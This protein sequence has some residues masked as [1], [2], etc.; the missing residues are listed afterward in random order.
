MGDNAFDGANELVVHASNPGVAQAAVCSGAGNVALWVNQLTEPCNN[1]K[2]VIP[3]GTDSFA[4]YGER[5]AKFQNVQLVSHARKTVINGVDLNTNGAIVLDLDSNTVDLAWCNVKTDGVA[6][7]LRAPR[8]DVTIRGNCS[9]ST[10]GQNAVLSRTA[11]YTIADHQISSRLAVTGKMLVAGSFSEERD[12]L[13]SAAPQYISDREF[14]SILSAQTLYFD[15]NGGTVSP[16]SKL[17]GHGKP[18]GE[19]PT[20][21][22]PGFRFD[23]WFTAPQGGSQ[24]SSSTVNNNFSDVTLYA[25]WSAIPYTVRW[26]SCDGCTITVTRT[27]SPNVGA[28]N[29]QLSSG[30]TV[31]YGD[32]LSVRYDVHSNYKLTGHGQTSITVAGDVGP[33]SIYA[34]TQATTCTYTIVYRSSNGTN[35]GSSSVTHNYGGTYTVSAPSKS[36]Y[37]TPSSQRVAWD[38]PNKTITFT[39]YPSYVDT[40]PTVASGTWWAHQGT[41]ALTYNVQVELRNRTATTIQARIKWTNRLR[42]NYYYGFGQY[43]NCL[44]GD[45]WINDSVICTASEWDKNSPGS[46]RDRTKFVYSDWVTLYVGTTDQKRI[47]LRGQYWQQGQKGHDYSG[48]FITPAY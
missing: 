31:Y 48:S 41:P 17:V 39:Y 34:N 18:Y 26:N 11:S 28:S 24:V 3:E 40:S 38:S 45:V 2:L 4:L 8:T 23:G 36:G 9:M 19:L 20:P 22:R 6:M 33:S 47:D 30:S 44:L 21:S 5:S 43:Y 35:L 12:S 7:V 14:E 1:C 13:V 25:H 10:S 32:T 37:D 46:S 42:A 16:S 15:A 29:G 27:S